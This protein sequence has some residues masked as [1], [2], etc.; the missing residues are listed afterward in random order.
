MRSDIHV[1]QHSDKFIRKGST[2]S[3]SHIEGVLTHSTRPVVRPN[4]SSQSLVQLEGTESAGQMSGSESI[5]SPTGS[6][7]TKTG[8]FFVFGGA[9]GARKSA[10]SKQRQQVIV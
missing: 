9:R 6:S 2:A 7:S 10:A 8:K 3:L 5:T 4:M 1:T